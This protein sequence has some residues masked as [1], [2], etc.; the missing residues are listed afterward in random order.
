MA[1]GKSM[2]NKKIVFI[3]GASRGIG[4]GI[5]LALAREQFIVIGNGRKYDPDD[6]TVGLFEVKKTIESQGGNF[7]PIQGDIAKSED[8]TR[9]VNEA[10]MKYGK[11]DIL[12]NNA[13]VAP[14][15]R[16]DVLETTQESFNQVF[17]VNAEAPFFLTQ[18]VANQMKSQIRQSDRQNGCI[19]FI[20][21]ISAYISSP[22]RAEYCISKAAVSHMAR[23]FAHRLSEYGINVYE[24]RPGIIKTDMTASVS[25]KYDKLIEEGLIPQNRWGHPEDVG[26]AV[27]AL[28][29]GYFAYSTGMQ[30][31]VSGGM[32]IRRL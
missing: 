15:T 1:K 25:E 14:Q 4:R 12:V 27:V 32:D 17:T 24:V 10:I 8:R 26:Q 7:F 13:G 18:L 6:E 23:I 21:S 19:I 16:L 22:S 20:S 28:A 31:E 30:V 29:K 9:M 11:I 5:A 2:N 3:T